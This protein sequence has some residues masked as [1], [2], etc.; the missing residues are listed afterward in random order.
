MFSNLVSEPIANGSE[1]DEREKGGG[2]FFVASGDATQVL[3]R[4]KKFSAW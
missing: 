4:W 2:E 3:M 1:L